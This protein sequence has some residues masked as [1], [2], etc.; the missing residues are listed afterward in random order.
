MANV[1][2]GSS[3][4]SRTRSSRSA[5]VSGPDLLSGSGANPPVDI[6]R[7]PRPGW[8]SSRSV[9]LDWNT[10][11]PYRAREVVQRSYGRSSDP[12]HIR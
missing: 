5:S 12:A 8:E 1:H 2:Q 10:S 6:R 11:A 7:N 3:G 4:S 9:R